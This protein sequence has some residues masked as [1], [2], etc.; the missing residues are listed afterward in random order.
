MFNNRLNLF[1]YN[2][3]NFSSNNR[4]YFCLDHLDHFFIYDGL[5]LLFFLLIDWGKYCFDFWFFWFRLC[6][7]S[8]YIKIFI[9]GYIFNFIVLLFFIES[10][11]ISP[12]LFYEFSFIILINKWVIFMNIKL[13]NNF[14]FYYIM[15]KYNN[16]N[17]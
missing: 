11:N 14:K 3:L 5:C 7:H 12:I 15:N 4:L 10:F 17:Q 1:S 16:I 6:A 8:L 2:F 13:S 9:L